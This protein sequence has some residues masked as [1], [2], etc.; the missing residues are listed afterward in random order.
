MQVVC[1]H[2]L[3]LGFS[4]M[5][6]VEMRLSDGT[7]THFPV[8]LGCAPFGTIGRVSGR[9]VMLCSRVPMVSAVQG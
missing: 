8:S 3:L 6:D 4:Y 5:F 7:V 2:D 1:V 9:G